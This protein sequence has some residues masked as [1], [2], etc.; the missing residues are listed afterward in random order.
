VP[1]AVLPGHPQPGRKGS[2]HTTKEI[3][4]SKMATKRLE[5]LLALHVAAAG[6]HCH[7]SKPKPK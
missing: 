7:G 6:A 1:E 3:T 2:G 4:M 5:E